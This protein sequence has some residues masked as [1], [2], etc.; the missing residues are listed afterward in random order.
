MG[1]SS[2]LERGANYRS[3][4]MLGAQKNSISKAA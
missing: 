3:V 1:E 4:A 2:P